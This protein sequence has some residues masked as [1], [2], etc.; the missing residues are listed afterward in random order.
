MKI[1]AIFAYLLYSEG[2]LLKIV[3]FDIIDPGI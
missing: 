2:G 1:S 3:I